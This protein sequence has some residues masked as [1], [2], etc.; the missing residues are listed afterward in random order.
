[1][2]D[3]I[4]SRPLGALDD[5]MPDID[6]PFILTFPCRSPS[7]T[8][9]L[10]SSSFG[11]L[12]STNSWLCGTIRNN[13]ATSENRAG[14]RFLSSP[15]TAN[16][17]NLRGDNVT[18]A[19]DSTHPHLSIQDLSQHALYAD[20]DYEA[21]VSEH[22]PSRYLNAKLLVPSRE[23]GVAGMSSV[24]RARVSFIRHGAFLCLC[25]SHAVMDATGLGKIAE[26][27]AMLARGDI[28]ENLH[29]WPISEQELGL[30]VGGKGTK[31]DVYG[32]LKG[33]KKLWH[34]LGLDYR[35]K[36]LT[37]AMLARDIPRRETAT[38]IFGLSAEQLLLL[39]ESC[40]VD[41]ANSNLGEEQYREFGEEAVER[42]VNSSSK[43]SM[44]SGG[45][46]VS[47][48]DALSALLWRCVVRARLR[49]AS[50]LAKSSTMMYAMNIRGLLPYDLS[51]S[52]AKMRR[53]RIANVV[54]YSINETPAKHLVTIQSLGDTAKDI[55]AA[56]SSHKQPDTLR[57]VLRLAAS[58]PDVSHLGLVYPTWLAEDVVIS[59]LFGL[60]LYRTHWG[61]A[62]GGSRTAPDYVR[63]PEGVFE[64][65]TFIMP[66][67]ENGDVEVVVTMIKE[68]M[69]VLLQ[70]VEW[71][72]HMKVL[73]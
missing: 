22:M 8:T 61:R 54:V 43:E 59:S 70:D 69:E 36:E 24:L 32:K 21:L 1:M 5:I 20:K 35:Q 45:S 52:D 14:T 25:T 47:T 16:G 17:N 4:S 44:R 55:R 67:R 34:M 30:N 15:L 72:E 11:T 66:Q 38:R 19:P 42:D 40:G 50:D 3:N 37:S 27:W 33:R 7:K 6:L 53:E 71:G 13:I 23:T 64:G 41:P 58:I 65:I 10:L 63:F 73:P 60:Q 2:A 31:A 39:K 57:D 9:E 28:V 56:V 51:E 29:H 26:A 68:D 62:F 48:N 12:L 49:T 46:W 18:A